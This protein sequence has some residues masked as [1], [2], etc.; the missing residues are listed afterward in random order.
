V[1]G[2]FKSKSLQLI[3][4]NSPKDFLYSSIRKVVASQI[5]LIRNTYVFTIMFPCRKDFKSMEI[6]L[7][8]PKD[9]L[10]D[11]VRKTPDKVPQNAIN[12]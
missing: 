11:Y 8:Y 4:A 5:N 10:Q 7:L 9:F 2:N 12:W 1:H 6:I 3:N